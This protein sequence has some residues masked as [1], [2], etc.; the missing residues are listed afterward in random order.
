MKSPRAIATHNRIRTESLLI[1]AFWSILLAGASFTT[2]DPDLWGHVR[3]G[4]DILRDWS[5]A[6][7]DPYSFTSDQPW[8]NHEWL[9]EVIMAT[10]YR[11]AGNA[12]L[13]LLKLAVIVST[14]WLVDLTVRREDIER[15]FVRCGVLALAIVLALNQVRYV[16]PQL[17]SVVAFAALMWCLTTTSRSSKRWLLLIPVLFVAWAN[18]H[19]G[20][21]VGGAVLAVWT[22]GVAL[23]GDRRG[24]TLYVMAGAAALAATLVTPYGF[25]LWSFLR[26]TVGFSRSDI[27]EWQPT[28][29]FGWAACIPWAVSV[30]IGVAGIVIGG[31]PARQ[32]ERIGCF[33]VLAAAALWVARL[34][35]FL[36]LAVMFLSGPSLAR[37]YDR[38]HS[39]SAATDHSGRRAI[40]AVAVCGIAAALVVAAINMTHLR[41][42]REI[43]PA[44]GAVA[45]LKSEPPAGGRLLVWFDWGEYAIWHLAP[46]LR[47]SIDGRRETVYSE[48]VR[49]RH[50]QFYLDEPGG[51]GLPQELAADYV[52]IPPY[53]PA[54]RGLEA[55]G[56]QRLY[57]DADS[58]VFGRA[59]SRTSNTPVAIAAAVNA[60]FPG[61]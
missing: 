16:R 55:A 14:L 19:G 33:V 3:F 41:I 2:T 22:L 54:V 17:F 45:F 10:A 49:D 37:A 52:W 13:I 48:A 24:A 18:V 27:T 12:G 23:G 4:L 35:A 42:G 34:Q 40:R 8:V 53:A 15:A 60:F 56:W 9:A 61:P 5:I 57:Q 29:A 7:A 44:P 20:W 46:R 32:P 31:R 1:G 21:V 25:H 58:V 50:G 51:A 59:G 6:R 43:I 30:V 47:V 39:I 38:A 28:Y 36:G 11:C 26:D